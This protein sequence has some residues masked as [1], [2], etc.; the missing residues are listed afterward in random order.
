MSHTHNFKNILS[1]KHL[2]ACVYV[3]SKYKH[4]R[5]LTCHD[6]MYTCTHVGSP[7]GSTGKESA[8]KAGDTI[9]A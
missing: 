1:F 2:L 6:C 4:T 9:L 3:Y 8:C 7:N 5:K